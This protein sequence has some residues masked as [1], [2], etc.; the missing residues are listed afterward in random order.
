MRLPVDLR[1]IMNSGTKLAE[2]RERLVRVAVF[3]DVAAP[4]ELV[5]AVREALRPQSSRAN[6]HVEAVA[7]GESLIIDDAVDAVI[8]VAGPGDTLLSSIAGSREKFVPT[9]VLA[10]GEHTEAVSRRLNHPLLDTIAEDSSEAVVTKLGAWLADRVS[11]K[12]LALAS[13]FVLVRRAVAY[14]AIKATAFQNGVIGAVAIIPGAD[15]PLMTANQA[16]MV[17]QIGA[18]YGVTLGAER[19]KELAA[20]VGG[21]FVFRAIARQFLDFVPGIGWA[22]KG[23]MGYSATLAVGYAAVEYFESGEDLSGLADRLRDARDKAVETAVKA[24]GRFSREP[25]VEALPAAGY[26]VTEAVDE[27]AAG[28]DQQAL[29]LAEATL[30]RENAL[31]PTSLELRIPPVFKDDAGHSLGAAESEPH[32]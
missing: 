31:S 25:A 15:L 29:P 27:Y 9:I 17:L 14:E 16:K 11:G 10:V 32:E 12:R 19:I 1:E 7:P 18:A 30:A 5:D 2:E 21:A 13:N 3:V 24:R 23:V 8:A 20:V 6:L 4:A 28:T 22:I 26:V